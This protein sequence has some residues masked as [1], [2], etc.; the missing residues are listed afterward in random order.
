MPSA[1][2]AQAQH[3]GEL[4]VAFQSFSQ[5]SRRLEDAYRLLQERL[6]KIDRELIEANERL[7]HKVDEL[8]SLTTFLN[9]VLASLQNGLIATDRQGRVTAFNPA[10]ERILGL[11]IAEALGRCIDTLFR[12]DPRGDAAEENPGGSAPFGIDSSFVIRHSSFRSPIASVL[13]TGQ[14][15]Q[16]VEREVARA[17]G[18]CLRLRSTVAPIHNSQGEVVGAVEVFSDLTEFRELQERLDRADKLAALGQ[19]AA[20]LAHEIRNPLNGIEGF[21][22]LLVRDLDAGDPRRQFAQHIVAGARSLNK[23]VTNMLDFAQP[24][25]P[26]PRPTSAAAV[27]EEALAYIAEECRHTGRENIALQ[28]DFAPEADA[29][30]ADPDLLRQAAMNLLLNSVQAMADGGAIRIVTRLAPAE[31]AEGEGW[32]E[33]RIEDSGPGIPAEVRDKVLEPFFTT[34]SKGTGLGLAIVQKIARVHGGQLD[35]QSEEGRG[36]TA[37][38][39]LPRGGALPGA[40]TRDTCMNSGQ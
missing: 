38:L 9:D 21:A 34:K 29:L 37:I 8:N 28:R 27:L 36:T 16:D 17:N 31:G 19:M 12:D 35:L 18:K 32:I 40:A 7:A 24:C 13:A 20:Q 30:L 39:R 15:I 14:V 33:L 2:P 26:Q 3:L 25:V 23:I 6:R 4:A 1:V 11:P 10:A 22:S 5:S